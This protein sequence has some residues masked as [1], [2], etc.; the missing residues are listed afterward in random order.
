MALRRCGA[1]RNFSL[2]IF[3]AV[4]FPFV[5]MSTWKKSKKNVPRSCKK[6]K[7][8]CKPYWFVCCWFF[9]KVAYP[10]NY[11]VVSLGTGFDRLTT[12]SWCGTKWFHNKTTNTHLFL[13]ALKADWPTLAETDW[14]PSDCHLHQSQPGLWYHAGSGSGLPSIDPVAPE[15]PCNERCRWQCL[16]V[17]H[18]NVD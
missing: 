13:S 11:G 9:F 17:N 14:H 16:P 10:L 18:Y 6:T 5:Y 2:W 8:A 3:L 15:S 1:V 4:H 7:K 12:C